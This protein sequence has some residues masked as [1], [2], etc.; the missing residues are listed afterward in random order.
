M[1]VTPFKKSPGHQSTSFYKDSWEELT[2][3]T[4]EQEQSVQKLKH[5]MNDMIPVS[6]LC[7]EILS[8]IMLLVVRDTQL[9]YLDKE[10]Y[11]GEIKDPRCNSWIRIAHICQYWRQVALKTG[12]IWSHVFLVGSDCAKELIAR[13]G[14]APLYITLLKQQAER[15]WLSEADGNTALLFIIWIKNTTSNYH[16]NDR[17]MVLDNC[18]KVFHKVHSLPVLDNLKLVNFRIS[19]FVSF[20][21]QSTLR[22]L[23]INTGTTNT[24][25]H[26]QTLLQILKGLPELKVVQLTNVV[27]PY[28][29]RTQQTRIPLLQVLARCHLYVSYPSS[30]LAPTANTCS[31]CMVETHPSYSPNIDTSHHCEKLAI[32]ICLSPISSKISPHIIER[33]YTDPIPFSNEEESLWEGID[34]HFSRKH[35][36]VPYWVEELWPV[37]E[38][39]QYTLLCPGTGDNGGVN[40]EDV[41]VIA[42]IAF[43]DHLANTITNLLIEGFELSFDQ[44]YNAFFSLRAVNSLCVGTTSTCLSQVLTYSLADETPLDEEKKRNIFIP[45]LTD[46]TIISTCF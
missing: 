43:K 3:N 11:E 33:T 6:R 19:M 12:R 41:I 36:N 16:Y 24:Q 27:K 1:E 21:S 32:N 17:E 37:P 42:L 39:S 38:M 26:V 7:P 45:E 20:A 18:R 34:I 4:S 40:P 15:T 30:S 8:N 2:R 14:T 9:G 29:A 28:S 13:S 5:Q 46:L 35:V 22:Y 23:D 44:F 31:Y 25:I 10:R